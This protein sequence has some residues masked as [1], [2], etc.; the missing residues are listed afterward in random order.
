MPSLYELLAIKHQNE[1]ESA[2]D[3]LMKR[4]FYSPK[5]YSAKGDLKKRWF[6]YFSFRDPKSGKLKRF[7]PVYGKANTY[8]T[9][10]ERLEV[11]VVYRKTLLKLLKQGFNTYSDNVELY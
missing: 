10:E 4:N 3:L 1:Y 6:V 11:L 7:T 8:K 2:Y 5:I 9:K